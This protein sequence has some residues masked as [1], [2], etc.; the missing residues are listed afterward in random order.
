MI[1]QLQISGFKRFAQQPFK[2]APLTVLA[3]MN[4]TGKTSVI[5]ALVLLHL[6]SSRSDGVVPLNGPYG[7][8]LGIYED[9]QN[10]DAS[11]EMF[12]EMTETGEVLSR[13]KF[14]GSQTALFAELIEAPQTIP[15]GFRA[16]GRMFQYLSAERFGPRSVLGASALPAKLLEVGSHGEYCAQVLQVLGNEIVSEERLCPGAPEDAAPLLKFEVERWLSRIA[17]P[18][19]IDVESLPIGT[20]SA[21]RFRVPGSEWV[22]PPNMGFG[23]TYALPVIVAALTAGLGGMVVVENPEAHLHPMGQSQMGHFLATMAAAG[24]QVVVE[25]H[26]DH[27]INGIRRAI[28][29]HRILAAPDAVVHFFDA[30]DT[31]PRLLSFTETGG[32]DAWPRGFFDQ[33]QIDVAALTRVRRPR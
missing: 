29:E 28:G 31:P 5:H 6:A 8:D 24:V 9:I 1:E 18:V 16:G 7:L 11:D 2:F 17:R 14:Q 13:W 25:T 12:F 33:Y 4:G 32:M 23:V 10:W 19:Q 20:V 22:R 30:A 26:S 3:G 15:A 27:L 21:L